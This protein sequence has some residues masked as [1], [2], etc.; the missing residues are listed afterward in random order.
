MKCPICG[1]TLTPSKKNPDYMLC[2]SCRKKFRI[3]EKHT[4]APA[5]T[6][7]VRTEPAV[8]DEDDDVEFHFRYAN[9]PPKEVREKQEREMRKAYDELLS[10][11]KEEKEKKRHGFRA[12]INQTLLINHSPV[13]FISLVLLEIEIR[14]IFRQKS[15]IDNMTSFILKA[16]IIRIADTLR[17]TEQIIEFSVI[18]IFTDHAIR[19]AV[20]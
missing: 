14:V 9:I 20:K 18:N 13:L 11:G 19:M 16:V 10:I 12:M 17:K 6:A 5:K 3:P 8:S 2:H 4:T 1:D 7:P 15:V